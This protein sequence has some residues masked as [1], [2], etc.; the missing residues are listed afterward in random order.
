MQTSEKVNSPASSMLRVCSALSGETVAVVEADEIEGKTVKMLKMHLAETTGAP[1]F[2]QRL[3][4]QDQRELLDDEF[5]SESEVQLLTLSLATPDEGQ[6]QKLISASAWNSLEEVESLLLLPIDPDGTDEQGVTALHKAARNGH[7]PC[8]SLLLEAMAAVD[9]EDNSDL[10]ATALYWATEACEEEK[11]LEVVQLLLQAG[12]VKDKDRVTGS[13]LSALHLAA[14]QGHLEILQLLLRAKCDTDLKDS[15]R[16]TALHWAIQSGHSE[17]VKLLLQAGADKD[18]VDPTICMSTSLHLASEKGDLEVMRLL[19]EAG[20]DKDPIDRNGRSALDLAAQEGHVE[21][22]RLLQAAGA[23]HSLKAMSIARWK[24]HKD[25]VQLLQEA[26]APNRW[27]E[28][29]RRSPYGN[30]KRLCAIFVKMLPCWGLLSKSDSDRIMNPKV[31]RCH[32]SSTGVWWYIF[33]PSTHMCLSVLT[34]QK[35]PQSN[36]SEWIRKTNS[37][38]TL[39]HFL[40]AQLPWWIWPKSFGTRW[41]GVIWDVS[42]WID[43]VGVLWWGCEWF[44]VFVPEER[45]WSPCLRSQAAHTCSFH[46]AAD[47][48]THKRM[49]GFGNIWWACGR[50]DDCWPGARMNLIYYNLLQ[51]FESSEHVTVLI[52]WCFWLIFSSP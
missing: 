5:V 11:H 44:A 32:C 42:P 46:P 38:Q 16:R 37:L 34:C 43:K 19:L 29:F 31:Q 12:A 47:A 25:I 36:E 24:G 40:P 23:K 10:R 22:V 3:Y 15:N 9:K 35:K 26:A 21:A 33:Y 39:N 52:R 4:N 13:G 41:V 8:V 50:D 30:A 49:T 6:D 18:S 48:R 28:A 51:V 45:H 27:T 20:A 14:N 17:V 7:S 2:R 1:R